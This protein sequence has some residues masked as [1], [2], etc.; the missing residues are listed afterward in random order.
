MNA[1]R[2]EH[3]GEVLKEE[4]SEISMTTHFSL[5]PFWVMGRMFL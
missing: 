3:P 1:M 2:P 4:L 5:G